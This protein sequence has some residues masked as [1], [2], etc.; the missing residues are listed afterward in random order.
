MQ[1]V[2]LSFLDGSIASLTWTGCSCFFFRLAGVNVPLPPDI[3]GRAPLPPLVVTIYAT[4]FSGLSLM[5]RLLRSRGQLVL[6]P[7][8]KGGGVKMSSRNKKCKYNV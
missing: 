3:L 5:V 8:L 7:Y 4:S 2:S 1:P 6:V